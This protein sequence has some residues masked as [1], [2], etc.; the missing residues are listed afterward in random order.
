MSLN[1]GDGALRTE[2]ERSEISAWDPFSDS[3]ASH[4]GAEEQEPTLRPGEPVDPSKCG[5]RHALCTV[6]SNIVQRNLRAMGRLLKH[7]QR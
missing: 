7:L 4:Q 3:A 5:C 2:D 6:V 1:Y